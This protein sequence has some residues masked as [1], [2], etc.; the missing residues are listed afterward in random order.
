MAQDN[1]QI[2]KEIPNFLDRNIYGYNEGLIDRVIIEL[3]QSPAIMEYLRV[4]AVDLATQL[5]IEIELDTPE[6]VRKNLNATYAGRISEL[7]ELFRLSHA[8]KI[9]TESKE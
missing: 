9:P 3:K 8:Q 1:Y 2:P 5:V 4:K 7:K 6:D